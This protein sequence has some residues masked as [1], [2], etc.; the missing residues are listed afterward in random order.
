MFFLWDCALWTGWECNR[1]EPWWSMPA[2]LK[3]RAPGSADKYLGVL[4]IRAGSCFKGKLGHVQAAGSGVAQAALPR[5]ARGSRVDRWWRRG[6]AVTAGWDWARIRVSWGCCAVFCLTQI[7]RV[8]PK[9]LLRNVMKGRWFKSSTSHCVLPYG[10]IN[11]FA[12]EIWFFWPHSTKHF[13]YLCTCYGS[14]LQLCFESLCIK[15][16]IESPLLWVKYRLGLSHPPGLCG[17]G[18]EWWKRA[19]RLRCVCALGVRRHWSPALLVH[20]LSPA[21]TIHVLD[22]LLAVTDC[23][24]GFLTSLDTKSDA[25]CVYLMYMNPKNETS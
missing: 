5:A 9:P 13:P 12:A 11:P 4:W 10:A 20:L 1:T 2:I 21:F 18:D 14:H 25:L 19:P 6:Q 7:S 16:P 24:L 23:L 3:S 8:S 17:M 15:T 22:A